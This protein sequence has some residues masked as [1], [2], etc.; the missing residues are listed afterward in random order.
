MSD[1]E[2]QQFFW[3]L[4]RTAVLLLPLQ[5]SLWYTLLLPSDAKSFY[6]KRYIN[7]LQLCYYSCK[8]FQTNFGIYFFFLSASIIATLSNFILWSKPPLAL[9]TDCTF[10][11]C[12]VSWSHELPR[13]DFFPFSKVLLIEEKQEEKKKE[14]GMKIDGILTWIILS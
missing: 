1:K 4:S 13:A 14:G 9:L 11:S 6:P 8:P 5:G 2:A 3:S 7:I 10:Q 12:F